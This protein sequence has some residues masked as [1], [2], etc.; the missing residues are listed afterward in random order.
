VRFGGGARKLKVPG[1]LK[2]SSSYQG[3]GE[4]A[5]GIQELSRSMQGEGS[6]LWWGEICKRSHADTSRT[7]NRNVGVKIQLR[8]GKKNF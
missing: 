6:K 8:L 2:V 3:G 1:R 5:S 4:C 7:R